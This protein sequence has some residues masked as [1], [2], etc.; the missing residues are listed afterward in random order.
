M[1]KNYNDRIEEGVLGDYALGIGNGYFI[2]GTLYTRLLGKPVTHGCIRVG[3][4]DLKIIYK[5]AQIGTKV[6]I[7]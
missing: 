4:N 3:D 1:P 2:H 7:F 5:S 6:Y